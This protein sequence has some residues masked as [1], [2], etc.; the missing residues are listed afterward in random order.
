VAANRHSED[1]TRKLS[2]VLDRATPDEHYLISSG[3]TLI[4]DNWRV[5]HG[6]AP[7]PDTAA[8]RHI[9]RVYLSSLHNT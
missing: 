3:D 7:V 6:R 2:D 5:L 1:V 8:Q 4:L 9:E